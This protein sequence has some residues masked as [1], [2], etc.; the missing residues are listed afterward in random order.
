M[1]QEE[2]RK[3]TIRLLIA[4][5]HT[6]LGT[7][8]CDEIRMK[9][10]TRASGLS[11]GAVFHYVNSMEELFALVLNKHLEEVNDRFM[12]RVDMET[13]NFQGPFQAITQ[14]L[15]QLE[16]PEEMTNKMLMY[17][18]GKSGQPPVAASLQAFYEYWVRLSRTWI[19]TGQQHGVIPDTVRAGWAAELFVLISFGLRT[20]SMIPSGSHTFRAVD[21]SD[22]IQ[23][24]LAP[25]GKGD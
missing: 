24:M 15:A 11:T 6:L 19:E 1:K 21:F 7:K 12:E 18:L 13:N 16:D 20:R 3:E 22:F 10:I 5:V 17:L 23:T 8:S 9:D 2:R 4:T 25:E 14:G